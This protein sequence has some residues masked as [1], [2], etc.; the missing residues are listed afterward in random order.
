MIGRTTLSVEVRDRLR[1]EILTGHLRPGDRL[2]ENGIAERYGVSPTPVREAIRLLHGDG[3]VEH[4]SHKGVRVIALSARQIAQCFSVRNVLERLALKEAFPL[5]SQ[6]DKAHLKFLAA[7]TEKAQGQPASLLYEIDREFHGF[8]VERAENMWLKTFAERMSNTLTVARLELFKAPE[9][10]KVVAEHNGIADAI[11]ADNL[12]LADQLLDAH[13][14]R[15]CTNALSALRRTRL[16]ATSP[17]AVG[18]G[19]E[20]D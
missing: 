6:E 19:E 12:P 9:I 17:E 4:T 15:V 16:S 5:M 18:K 7:E 13:I 8:F 2:N 10:D 3:L 20:C 11:L 14:Q 1:D